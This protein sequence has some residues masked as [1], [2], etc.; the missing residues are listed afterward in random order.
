LGTKTTV[1]TYPSGRDWP[2]M[3][4]LRP[5]RS[6]RKMGIGLNPIRPIYDLGLLRLLLHNNPGKSFLHVH[7]HEGG[8]LGRVEKALTGHPYLLDLEGSFIEEASRTLPWM[9]EGVIGSI[10]MRLER[11]LEKSA[12][13]V[14]VSSRG[15]YDTLSRTGH[16][17]SGRLHHIPDG[18][19]VSDFTP[20]SKL[21]T[22]ALQRM[23]S[24]Y[25]FSDKNVIAVYVGGISPQQG[26]DEI[27]ENA[28]QMLRESPELRFLI[29]GTASQLNSMQTYLSR[30]KGLGLEGKVVFP[31]PIPF[32]EVPTA[33]A[34]CDI[35]LTWKHSILEG[36]GKIPLY[37]AA[38]IPTVALETPAHLHYFGTERSRG[39][40]VTR[41]IEGAVKATIS[42]SL[43]ESERTTMGEKARETAERDLS[44]DNV[45]RVLLG[46]HQRSAG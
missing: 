4:I 3:K 10:G 32:E 18:V 27:L 20:R 15:L 36:S 41:S 46:L 2:G 42:L 22:E 13:Q 38:G 25:G 12:S 9:A 17:P 8:T 39:G 5:H 23:R 28:P 16:I 21:P 11:S 33:M 6:D 7:L 30:V 14:V 1:L 31:G 37:M 19:E 26:I 34:A 35:G 44:W 43:N 29:Y 24:K 40:I 45:A